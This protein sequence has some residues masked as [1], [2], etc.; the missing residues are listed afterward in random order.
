MVSLPDGGARTKSPSGLSSSVW[1]LARDRN[2]DDLGGVH[3]CDGLLP[4][5]VLHPLTDLSAAGSW[6][7]VVIALGEKVMRHDEL[8]REVAETVLD[9]IS[10]EQ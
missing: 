9:D 1:G 2:A 4:V 8:V 5:N 10:R 6:T 7:S 3:C